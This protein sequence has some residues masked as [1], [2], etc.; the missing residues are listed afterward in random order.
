MDVYHK[1]TLKYP[2]KGLILM[3][4]YGKPV[5]K[6][7]IKEL[8]TSKMMNMPCER[9]ISDEECI[10]HLVLMIQIGIFSL[11][12]MEQLLY[13]PDYIKLKSAYQKK[14]KK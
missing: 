3:K 14:K 12:M 1:Y 10:N 13:K 4:R 8:C 2:L 5:R 9:W 7:S 11:D 6:C